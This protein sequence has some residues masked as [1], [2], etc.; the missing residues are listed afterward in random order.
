MELRVTN[1]E[2]TDDLRNTNS[3][4]YSEFVKSF[5][6]QVKG[7]GEGADPIWGCDVPGC[8]SERIS[9]VLQA[10]GVSLHDLLWVHWDVFAGGHLR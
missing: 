2:F 10:P 7:H 9:W 4:A 8:A 1:R 6:K 5:T 3:S